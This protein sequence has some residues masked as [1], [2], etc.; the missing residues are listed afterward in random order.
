MKLK[1][2]GYNH[3]ERFEILKAGFA[4]YAK[5]KSLEKQNVRPFYR[6][7]WFE[8][9]SG[10]QK[11]SKC[12]W[13]RKG[14]KQF[15]TVIFVNATPNGELVRRLRQ[16]EAKHQ[17]ASDQRVRFIERPGPKL[18]SKISLADPFRNGC[19]ENDC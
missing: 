11:I 6:P 19:T 1:T 13:F 3:S 15:S 17:I 2:S 8:K 12:D 7:P 18:I 5:L 10:S 14:N 9:V 16:V 4:T